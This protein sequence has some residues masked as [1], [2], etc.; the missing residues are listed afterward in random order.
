MMNEWVFIDYFIKKVSFIHLV[1]AYLFIMFDSDLGGAFG[2][3][4]EP[5]A[6]EEKVDL[7]PGLTTGLFDLQEALNLRTRPGLQQVL[8]NKG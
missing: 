2:G 5:G 6:A 1:C 3:A 8:R 4:V 7:L